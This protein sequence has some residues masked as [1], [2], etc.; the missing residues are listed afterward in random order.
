MHGEIKL[1][2]K[3][4]CGTR[5]TFWLPFSKAVGRDGTA[6]VDLYSLSARLQSETSISCCS[7]DSPETSE[8]RLQDSAHAGE[9]RPHVRRRTTVET[10]TEQERRNFHVL[11]VEDK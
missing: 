5:A 10:L 11:V 2:S 7:S 9:S 8:T 3:I 1:E 6:P 4:D